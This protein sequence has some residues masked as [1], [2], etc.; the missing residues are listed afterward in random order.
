MSSC[1]LGTSVLFRLRGRNFGFYRYNEE[2]I[3]FLDYSKVFVFISIVK[4]FRFSDYRAV[5]KFS[6]VLSENQ[7]LADQYKY[8]YLQRKRGNNVGCCGTK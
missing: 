5:S 1:Y 3:I 2:K 4:I 6:I 8:F 7:F